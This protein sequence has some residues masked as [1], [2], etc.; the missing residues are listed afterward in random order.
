MT[1]EETFVCDANC[2]I[3]LY[4]HFGDA[5]LKA[6]RRLG[7]SR[8][9]K[10]PEGVV[11]EIMRGTDKL[12]KFLKKPGHALAIRVSDTVGLREEIAR[13]ETIYGE[14]IRFGQKTYRGFWKSP[15][16]RQA[17]DAQVIAVAKKLG[18]T[19][20]SDDGA[21][22]LACS[23]EGVN[24]IGWAEFARQI[25]LVKPKQLNLPFAQ[26]GRDGV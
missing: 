11:R 26:E 18:A 10:L 22:Q 2:L 21:I 20:V 8:A 6:L 16:G 17:A 4:R 5:S 15:A 23:L 25:G 14:R 24:C 12:A 9:L 13:L 19:A 7:E 1:P 3:N